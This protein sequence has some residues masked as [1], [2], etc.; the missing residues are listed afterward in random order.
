MEIE[1]KK[2]ISSKVSGN[3]EREREREKDV[4]RA[5]IKSCGIGSV[6]MQ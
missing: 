4:N 2:M 3:T 1:N 5:Y 6:Y